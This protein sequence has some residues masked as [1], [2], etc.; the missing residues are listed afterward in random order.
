MQKHIAEIFF[1]QLKGRVICD[2]NG[3]TV[4]K[5]K[6]VV[7]LWSGS[8]PIITGILYSEEPDKL[9][10]ADMVLNWDCR[11]V[12]LAGTA[13]NI[14]TKKISHQELFVG[15]W[16]L[17]NQVIDLKG[18]KIVRVNDILLSCDEQD[19]KQRMSIIAA[20]IGIRGLL[21]RIGLEF[22]GSRLEKKYISWQHMTPL[23]KRTGSLKLKIDRD[24]FKKLHPVDIADLLED[25]DYDSRSVFFKALGAE[26][27]A[28]AIGKLKENT[29]VEILTRM[30]KEQAAQLLEDLHAD[31][32]ANILRE[33]PKEK[34]AELLPLLKKDKAKELKWLLHYKNDT[35]G[36]LMTTEFIRLPITFTA[37]QAIEHLRRFAQDAEMIYY[38]Y[39]TDVEEKLLGAFSLR[40]LI[41]AEPEITLGNLMHSKV[42]AVQVNDSRKK[43][44]EIIHKYGLLAVPV[45]DAEGFLHG[46]VTVD[47]VLDLFMVDRTLKAAMS[48]YLNKRGLR[49]K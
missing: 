5:V 38:L 7:T 1:S 27:A 33:M 2:S 47:D 20:D 3:H 31:E 12:I 14:I 15:K 4:G 46:I 49:R 10:P 18:Y 40:E 48:R 35:A 25:M 8:L 36:S 45:L 34:E 19:G 22:L 24:H 23:E 26:Q 30:D 29:Q 17:D 21:R 28:E 6:D 9:I 39:V 44:A 16:L 32:A 11:Q 43:V 13:E 37:G 42:I 41:L